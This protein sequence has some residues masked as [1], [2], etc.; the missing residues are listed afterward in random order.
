MLSA[1]ETRI[2]ANQLGSL[3]PLPECTIKVV[4]VKCRLYIEME[5]VSN[6]PQQIHLTV[7]AHN[8]FHQN[9]KKRKCKVQNLDVFSIQVNKISLKISE[10]L[11]KYVKY[12]LQN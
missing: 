9:S 11:L 5:E 6:I 3:T 12:K 2:F 1:E 10:F 4:H 8:T 7:S